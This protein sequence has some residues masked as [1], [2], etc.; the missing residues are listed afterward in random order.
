MEASWLEDRGYPRSLRSH[1]VANGW[2]MPIAHGVVAKPGIKLSWQAIV[3]SL[4]FLMEYDVLVG[5]R[6]ALKVHGFA[7]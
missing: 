3:H 2:L 4:Q 1:Y 5:G 7:H 6:T